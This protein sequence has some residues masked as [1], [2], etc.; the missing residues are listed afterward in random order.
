MIFYVTVG[1][2]KGTTWVQIVKAVLL[3]TGSALIVV[4]VLAQF[5]F[6][7]SD[8]LGSAATQ[9]TARARRSCSPGLKYGVTHD[10]KIDFLSLGLALVLGTA[11]L[12]HILI[13]FYTD[14]DL[15]G[16]AEVGAVGDR[17][18]RHLL[19]DVTLVLGFG[20]A[21][22]LTDE[23]GLD[24]A[25]NLAVTAAGECGRRRRRCRPVARSC[26]R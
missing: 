24:P 20:A 23:D 13:R 3:M 21:A 26:W 15:A 19:P 25:G 6:N 17:A 22:L 4:L 14:A 1:G 9:N 7:L 5:N 18:D 8:L 11:G 10:S 12:P 16:R 2:M